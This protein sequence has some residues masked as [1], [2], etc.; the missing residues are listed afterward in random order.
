MKDTKDVKKAAK[1]WPSPGGLRGSAK[2]AAKYRI[3]MKGMKHVSRQ[4]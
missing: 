2:P 3:P 4:D 1:G